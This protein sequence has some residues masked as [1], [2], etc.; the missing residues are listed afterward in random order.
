VLVRAAEPLDGWHVDLTGP[1]R[2][3]KAFGVTRADNGMDLSVGEIAF[4][5]DPEYR[6]RVSRR[7]R[8]GIDYS[9]HWKHRLLR[10]VDSRN[11]VARRLRR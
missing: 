1:G 6:P 9:R 3:A 11:P 4:Y 8:I 10:F 7:K 2:V 5:T